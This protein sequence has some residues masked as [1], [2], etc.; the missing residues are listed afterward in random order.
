ML[1]V[2]CG[3]GEL[4]DRVSNL[5]F[6][7]LAPGRRSLVVYRD[8]RGQSWSERALELLPTEKREV[9]VQERFAC[10]V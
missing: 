3:N 8:D 9:D 2:N 5:R 4:K 10:Q 6:P 7:G 1:I